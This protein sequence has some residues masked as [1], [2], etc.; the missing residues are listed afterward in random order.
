MLVYASAFGNEQHIE[1]HG[2]QQ[3]KQNGNGNVIDIFVARFFLEQ[4]SK[5]E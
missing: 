5:A 3:E 4:L 1:V 2:E